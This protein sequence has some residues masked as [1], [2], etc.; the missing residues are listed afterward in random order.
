MAHGIAS[1]LGR[2]EAAMG[3]HDWLLIKELAVI[4]A[5]SA[6]HRPPRPSPAS[7]ASGPSPPRSPPAPHAARERHQRL[8]S[9]FMVVGTD[10]PERGGGAERGAWGMAWRRAAGFGDLG[11]ETKL[12]P[13]PLP[14][15]I[16]PESSLSFASLWSID[17]DES[18]PSQQLLHLE[19][20]EPVLQPCFE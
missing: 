10:C 13:S 15:A 8:D 6:R 7:A 12:T 4:G 20:T 2:G 14:R 17:G 1:A 9:L 18:V 19:C 11:V 16:I 5:A 3:R